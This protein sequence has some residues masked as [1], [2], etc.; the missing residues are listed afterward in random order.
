MDFEPP[1]L[2]VKG[3]TNYSKAVN[4]AL[5]II[6]ARK[7]SYR[8]GGI[9][10]YRSLAY[11]LTDGYPEHDNDADLAQAASRLAE[12]E[13]NRSVAFFCFGI[14]SPDLPADMSALAK[15]SP[16][17]PVELT[18]MEQLDGSIQWLSRSVA[19]VSQSPA[20]RQHP[21]ARARLPGLLGQSVE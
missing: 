9:A 3:G 7:R 1:V 20:R 14:G 11:F 18:N 5:D 15:L 13:Q 19:A 6:E 10:Y 16:R 21:P 12:M 17:Q 4:L 8:D 2:S